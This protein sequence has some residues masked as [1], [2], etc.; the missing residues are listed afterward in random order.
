ML[1]K[2]RVALITGAGRGLGKATAVAMAGEGAS[3]A[4]LSRT[5]A[6]LE[7]T[8]ALVEKAGGRAL[9]L[10][11]DVTDEKAVREA[12]ARTGAEMDGI[13]IVV[14]CASIVGPAE[15]LHEVDPDQWNRT[16]AVNLTG[17]V[18]VCQETVPFM[19]RAGGGRIVN[20]TSGLAQIV[21][22]MF[23]AYS[24]SKA[25]VNHLTRIMAEELRGYGIQVNGL[26]PGV[27]DTGMQEEIRRMGPSVLGK[28]LHDQFLSFKEGGH[29]KHPGEVARLAV[30]LAS[31]HS[32][33]ITGEIGGAAEFRD[34]GYGLGDQY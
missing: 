2:D 11:A 27:M 19:I 34:Y 14:N 6:E 26:D 23:G 7:E 9:V 8:A 17:V 4:L 29:L 12:A 33:G 21:M 16:L 1:L 15:P 25:G 10:P 28:P 13:N 20:V 5:R 3:V 22:P 32:V 30:F 18:R 24:V 31:D